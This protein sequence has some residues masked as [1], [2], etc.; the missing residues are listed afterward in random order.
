MCLHFSVTFIL[1][2]L[3]RQPAMFSIYSLQIWRLHVEIA[4]HDYA[5]KIEGGVK[6]NLLHVKTCL[7]HLEQRWLWY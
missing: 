4:C 5:M 3:A 1:K 2:V 6:K 7:H